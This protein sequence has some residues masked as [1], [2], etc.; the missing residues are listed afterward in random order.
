MRSGKALIPEIQALLWDLGVS[1]GGGG[2]S[3]R[4]EDSLRLSAS[5][6]FVCILGQPPPHLGPPAGAVCR[7]REL[8]KPFSVGFP[9]RDKSTNKHE[10]AMASCCLLCS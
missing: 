9:G 10:F 5:A 6:G 8:S 3:G 1:G 2:G 7:A 4:T